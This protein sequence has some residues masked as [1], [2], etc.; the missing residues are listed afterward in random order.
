M[1]SSSAWS[2]GETSLPNAVDTARR[3]TR[4][5]REAWLASLVKASQDGIEIDALY[6]QLTMKWPGLSYRT[7]TSEYLKAAKSRGE[8]HYQ[9]TD[10]GV[11]VVA[12]GE[13]E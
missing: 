10:K 3:A 9:V 5:E 13:V 2:R 8:I 12:G 1:S 11:F 6:G 7:F 4:A